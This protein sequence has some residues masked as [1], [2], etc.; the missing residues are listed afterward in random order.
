MRL[1]FFTNEPTFDSFLSLSAMAGVFATRLPEGDGVD[2]G[3]GDG[4]LDGSTVGLGLA[5][6]I[7]C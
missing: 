3:D 6:R 4:D 7:A 5:E 2:D 1:T